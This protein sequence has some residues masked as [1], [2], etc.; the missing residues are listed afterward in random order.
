[1]HGK[2][3]ICFLFIINDLSALDHPLLDVAYFVIG[4][5]IIIV[6]I[7]SNYSR[8]YSPLTTTPRILQRG[9]YN[10]REIAFC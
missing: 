10:L 9:M 6:I 2:D 3:I 1:M 7:F 5:T 4:T 8:D